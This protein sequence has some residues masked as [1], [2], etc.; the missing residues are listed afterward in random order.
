MKLLV[1]FAVVQTLTKTHGFGSR[2]YFRRRAQQMPAWIRP[3]IL[4]PKLKSHPSTCE[5]P[6]SDRPAQTRALTRIEAALFSGDDHRKD[7]RANVVMP[8]GSG[9]TRVGMR[10]VERALRLGEVKG[11]AT[12]RVLVLLPR[13]ALLEQT[14]REYMSFGSDMI[15]DWQTQALCVCSSLSLDLQYTTDPSVITGH[16]T[17]T[18]ENKLLVFSTYASVSAIEIATRGQDISFSLVVLDE[19]HFTAGQGEDRGRALQNECVLASRRLFLTATPRLLGKTKRSTREGE[20]GLTTLRSM[21]NELLFGPTVYS[22]KRSEA[23]AFGITVPVK[24]T[25]VHIRRG[26]GH[27]LAPLSSLDSEAREVAFKALAIQEFATRHNLKKIISF[28][29][30]NARSRHLH[31]AV[32]ELGSIECTIVNGTMRAAEREY[33][34]SNAQQERNIHTGDKPLLIS[35]ARLLTEGFDL[36]TC[37]GVFLADDIKSHVT[38]QQ[39]MA[40]AARTVPGKE[41][42]YVCVPLDSEELLLSTSSYQNVHQVLL[43]MVQEDGELLKDLRSWVQEIG[44]VRSSSSGGADSISVMPMPPAPESLLDMVTFPQG[45]QALDMVRALMSVVL[46]LIGTWDTRLGALMQ[47]VEAHGDCN[48]PQAYETPGGLKLGLWVSRQRFAHAA[49]GLNQERFRRLDE[50]GFVWDVLS[51]EW[52]KNFDLLVRYKQDN[53]DTLVPHKFETEDGGVK[54]GLWVKKQRGMRVKGT[55]NAARVDRLTDVGFEWDATEAEW[56]RNFQ[57]LVKYSK[58]RDSCAVPTSFVTADGINIGL[59]ASRQ[60]STYS[61][62]LLSQSRKQRL[63]ELGFEWNVSHPPWEESVLLLEK[64]RK[65]NGD[66]LVP[67]KYETEPEGVKLGTWV[68]RQRLSKTKETLDPSR[69]LVLENLGFVWRLKTKV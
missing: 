32:S 17:Q 31:Q 51:V 11:A 30:T 38:I 25:T 20:D 68:K 14:V 1:L 47:Y 22:L 50:I 35:N 58:D 55:L 2:H 49:G 36:P 44:K 53:G 59:W 67:M 63:Q 34:L 61:K 7:K 52:H 3:N 28:S 33:V 60:R 19:A 9:K 37:D 48:V 5:I 21:D 42:G 57:R 24:L 65:E 18:G 41:C 69:I 13:L 43:S 26:G 23:I 12:S 27:L 15:N 45:T 64:Y 10:V 29:R 4:S 16:L 46:D 8:G 62:G 6:H 56:D 66:C 40:R 39:A 54:L